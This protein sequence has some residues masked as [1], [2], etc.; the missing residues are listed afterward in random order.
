MLV[1]PGKNE[2]GND[3]VLEYDSGAFVN[4][5]RKIRK[6]VA[7]FLL[8]GL[9]LVGLMCD[10]TLAGVKSF[11]FDVQGFM[12]YYNAA[13]QQLGTS[14]KGYVKSSR[15]TG[16]NNEMIYTLGFTGTENLAAS[17]WA[18][19][20]TRAVKQIIMISMKDATS[21]IHGSYGAVMAVE[22][23]IFIEEDRNKILNFMGLRGDNMKRL[24]NG[25]T[26]NFSI[27]KANYTVQF[28]D[29]VGYWL[30][31]EPK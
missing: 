30:T 2:S 13:S 3:R 22:N 31:I 23:N 27:E 26:L 19:I 28:S 6:S 15:G 14:F 20:D 4:S 21:I 24:E 29:T 7:T 17:V 10:V 12:S 1:S 11:D 5:N 18:D 25:E 16:N 9:M 8:A